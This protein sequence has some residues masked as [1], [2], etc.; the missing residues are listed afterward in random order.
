M[1]GCLIAGGTVVEGSGVPRLL[2]VSSGL[3]AADRPVISGIDMET[4][5]Y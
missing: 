3:R 5:R 4:V 2:G 1:L